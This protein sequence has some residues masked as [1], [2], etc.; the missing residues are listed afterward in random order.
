[1]FQRYY[2]MF[3]DSELLDLTTRAASEL[4]IAVG[5]EFDYSI[6]NVEV[7]DAGV[8]Y[9]ME[10]VKTGWERSNYYL[11]ARMWSRKKSSSL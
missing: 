7:G 3:A 1:M 6:S 8:I 10:V 2:H 5:T 4:G 11:E 9:G